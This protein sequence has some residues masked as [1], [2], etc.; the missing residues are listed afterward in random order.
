MP[1]CQ[2]PTYPTTTTMCE[3]ISKS[4][5]IKVKLA[6]SENNS[7]IQASCDTERFIVGIPIKD[8]KW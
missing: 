5:Y 4:G 8:M 3:V 6:K 2:T 7:M 1:D